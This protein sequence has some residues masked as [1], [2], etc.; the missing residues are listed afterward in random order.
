MALSPKAQEYLQI[1]GVVIGAVGL[2]YVLFKPNAVSQSLG[3]SSPPVLIGSGGGNDGTGLSPIMG[4]GGTPIQPQPTPSLNF[5]PITFPT[6]GPVTLPGLTIP[7][8][9]PI[10]IAG[11]PYNNEVINS[12]GGFNE[13]AAP[14]NTI[15]GSLANPGGTGCC[16]QTP[17]VPYTSAPKI[18]A[19]TV[20]PVLADDPGYSSGTGYTIAG[21]FPSINPAYDFVSSAG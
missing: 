5:P 18:A 13:P 7:P 16:A 21:G 20:P 4:S 9:A 1:S 8:N 15:L 10:D 14:I 3:G 6:N 17:Q 11:N 19:S 2:L 12:Y